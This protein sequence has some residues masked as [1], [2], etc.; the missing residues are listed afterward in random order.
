MHRLLLFRIAPFLAA[1]ILAA[2]PAS[3]FA[4]CANPTGLKSEIIYNDDFDALQFCDGQNWISMAASGTASESDPQVDQLTASKWCKANAGAT[5]IDCTTTA[6]SLST[7]VTG[8]L[9]VGNLNSGTSASSSTFWRGDGAWA[10]PSGA[11]VAD[12]DKGDITV[13]SSGAVWTIDSGAVTNAMLAGSIAA[14]KLVGTDIATVG[15]IT[16]GVWS[17]TAIAVTKGGTGLTTVAQGALLYGSAADTISALAK[18]TTTT[19]YLSNTGASNSPAWAQINLADGV[20]GNLPVG[21]LNSGTSAS[22]STFWRGD[23]AWATP[24]ASVADGDKGDITVSSSGAVW[25]IDN[26]AVTNAMLAGSIAASKLV[27]TD[28]ATV[29][30]ITSGV[31]NAG[32]VTSSGLVTGTGFAPTATTA[33]GN[34]LYLPAANTL[35]LA[36]NGAGEVQLTGTAL[37]P[38][39]SDGNA[40]GTSSL[41]W[42]DLFLASGA[43]INFNNGDVTATHSANLLAWAGA[44]SGYTF[45][46]GI[47]IGTTSVAATALLDMVSTTK[48]FLPPRMTTAQVNAISSPPDGLLAYDTDTDTIKLRA[49]GAWASL[50]AGGSSQWTTAGSDIYYTTGSVGIGTTSPAGRLVVVGGGNLFDGATRFWNFGAFQ[51]QTNYRGVALGYDTSE[52]IGFVVAGSGGTPGQLSFGID[53]GSGGYDEAMRLVVGGDVGI[54]TTS[55]AAKLNVG[56]LTNGDG[57][58]LSGATANHSFKIYDTDSGGNLYWVFQPGT[59]ANQPTVFYNPSNGSANGLAVRNNGGSYNWLNI[60]HTDA[61]GALQTSGS[62]PISLQPNGGSVGIGTSNPGQKL[63]VAGTIESTSGGVKFPDGTTQT[64]AATGGGGANVQTFT[65]SGTWTKPGSGAIA[66]AECWGGGGGGARCNGCGGGGGGG[67]NS[68]W[69]SLSSLGSTETVTVGSGGAGKTGSDGSGTNGGNSSVG[70]HL[71]A[72]GGVGGSSGTGGGGGGMTSVGSSYTSGSPNI[73]TQG[74]GNYSWSDYGG[75]GTVPAQSGIW[76]GGGGGASGSVSGAGSLYG[77]GGGGGYSS[78]PGGTSVNAGSGGQGGTCNGCNATEGTQP[79]GGGG[80]RGANGGD[81]GAG[82]CRI[83]VF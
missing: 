16:T 42:A 82:Q 25:S 56:G 64:T 68:R 47:G 40:L 12:G 18:N 48:G 52:Q 76:H 54:G 3:L 63:T 74:Y 46:S 72:Y 36:I 59:A 2:A 73:S 21:N 24:S 26:T 32:A 60:Y 67:Y 70:S 83:I 55:P 37:S 6:I 11:S 78:G 22:S 41:M 13:S 65:A 4:D 66:M 29:G 27:G 75:S 45:D 10:A 14:S 20:T 28:I 15:T 50:G 39:T 33:T 51:D 23:G 17:G 19:R 5:A 34:R 61:V 7:D 57:L 81:G 71:T 58:L 69:I 80:A 44:S 43:V 31:W 30:T 53:D 8:N 38:I 1:A 9:P 49:N 62:T 35:G 77:G 79:G